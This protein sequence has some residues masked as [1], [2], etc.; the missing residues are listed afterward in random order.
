MVGQS[1]TDPYFSNTPTQHIHVSLVIPEVRPS[2]LNVLLRPITV[3]HSSWYKI[4]N[5]LTNDVLKL[6]LAC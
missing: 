4:S 2:R 1:S 3:I 6:L 5:H